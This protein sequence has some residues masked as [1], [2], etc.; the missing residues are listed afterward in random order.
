MKH[1]IVLAACANCMIITV[2]GCISSSRSDQTWFNPSVPSNPARKTKTF[3]FSFTICSVNREITDVLEYT[4]GEG[5]RSAQ[6]D[7]K[8]TVAVQAKMTVGFGAVFSTYAFTLRPSILNQQSELEAIMDQKSNR[9]IIVNHILNRFASSP[10][11]LE[12]LEP[13]LYLLNNY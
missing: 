2:S 3:E 8:K 13:A 12:H 1:L 11:L 9:R 7:G 6:A 10:E 4:A 5:I